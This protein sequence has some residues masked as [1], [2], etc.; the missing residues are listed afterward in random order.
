MVKKYKTIRDLPEL[1]KGSILIESSSAIG[2][3]YVCRDSDS[4]YFPNVL[5]VQ[6][7]AV[8][9]E[10]NPKWFKLITP[11]QKYRVVTTEIV[12]AFSSRAAIDGDGRRISYQKVS[13]EVEKI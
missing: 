4:Q 1:K 13:R 5:G 12:E 8:N 10:D 3:S 9:V 2:R 11:F 7:L 6:Y